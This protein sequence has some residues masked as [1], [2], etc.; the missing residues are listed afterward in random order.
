MTFLLSFVI[1]VGMYIYDNSF[2][3]ER[4]SFW[5]FSFI[6]QLPGF[7]VGFLLYDWYKSKNSIS[8]PGIKGWGFILFSFAIFFMPS[9]IT[10]IVL[11]FL[12]SLG[13]YYIF[14]WL[15]PVY[16]AIP[17]TVK[18]V[19]SKYG[20]NSYAIYLIHP[21][22]AFELSLLLISLVHISHPILYLLWLPILYILVLGIGIWYNKFI[23]ITKNLVFNWKRR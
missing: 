19:L 3:V 2:L 1:L 12:F 11:P 18:R 22:L 6:N 4:N 7:S 21:Y 23:E 5:Y 17:I 20:D 13:F 8:N 15:V 14:L 16:D 10:Y 9:P